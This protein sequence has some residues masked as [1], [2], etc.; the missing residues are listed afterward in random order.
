MPEVHAK[1]SPSSSHRWLRC[2]GSL[3]LEMNQPDTASPFAIEGTAAHAL[4]ETVLN[5]R[6]SPKSL[7]ESSTMGQ[8]T[9]DYLGQHILL[10]PNTPQVN[11]E[12]VEAVGQYVETIWGLA[13]GKELLIEQRVDFSEVIG[14]E[15]S[16]GTADAIIINGSELQIH[17]LKYGKGVKVDAEENEQL[18]LYALGALDQFDMLYDF[19]TVRL[20]IHQPRLNHIS[21]WAVNVENLRQFGA[22]AK[23]AAASVITIFNI[24]QCEGTDTLPPDTFTPG[25]KQCRFCKANTLCDALTKQVR[26]TVLDDFDDL[27][28]PL[29]TQI[30]KAQAQIPHYDHQTLAAKY[31]QVDFIESW[32]K[33]VRI[34]VNDELNAGH[35]VPGFKLVEGKQGDRSWG[36]EADAEVMLKGF[37]LKQDQMYT[38]KL[39]TPPQAEKVLKKDYPKKWSKLE[40]LIVRSDGKPTVV[41]ESD[42]RP[43]LDVNPINDFEDVSD[44]ALIADLI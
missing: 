38:K 12:M 24:A 18:M 28:L 13:Q 2:H 42:P 25:E 21:E 9:A 40:S 39:I 33:A 8:N 10:K 30:E 26:S 16:F 17:D 29:E 36:V 4:A 14:V 20:F 32:C 41:P 43:A 27:T 22:R 44:D 19:E 5:N 15:N 31:A 23:D 3:A 34:R 1:L 6:Q 11:E 37:K 7:I 35:T